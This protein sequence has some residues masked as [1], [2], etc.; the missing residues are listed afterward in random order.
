MSMET[1]AQSTEDILS[2]L[3]GRIAIVGNATPRHEFGEVIDQYD[4]VIRLNNFRIAGFEKFVGSKTS[5]RCT[6]GWTDIEHRN[7]HLEFSPFTAASAESTNLEAYNRANAR[8]LL[9]ARTDIHPL[10]PETAK[11]STGFS[12]IQLCAQ[13][14]LSVDLFGFD[15]FKSPHYWDAQKTFS[16]THSNQE[17]DFILQRPGVLV[18]GDTYAYEKLYDF[19]HEEHSA[20]DQNVGLELVRW[21]KKDFRG[22]A[23]LEFGSGNGQL[24]AHLEK[25]GNN[26][27]AIEASR[28]AFEKI[29]C[30]K[31]IHG[32]ALS[33]PLLQ[34][35]FDCF[36]SVD[37]LEHLTENDCRLVIR[38]AARLAKSIFVSVSTRPSGLLGPNGENLHLTVKPTA[39]WTQ[40]FEKFFT[41][42]T[43]PGYGNGQLVIEGKRKAS[44]ILNLEALT[45][46]QT[47]AERQN[48]FYLNLFTKG[49]AWALATP[50][51]DEA[52]RWQQIE[53]LVR[54]IVTRAETPD[55]TMAGKKP[56]K[57]TGEVPR[58]AS[59]RILDLGC[60]RGWLTHLLSTY[61]QAEGVEPVASVIEH[62]RRLFPALQF[63]A[64]NA[65]TIL[66]R[67]NFT[68][69]D[70]VV[71]SEVIEHVTDKPAFAKD[72]KRLLKPDGHLILTTPRGEALH[73]WTRMF[74]DP[75]QPVEDWMT[76][77]QVKNVF[78][79]SGFRSLEQK[80][81]WFDTV[82]RFFTDGAGVT[83]LENFVAIYQVWSFQSVESP[84]P[85]SGSAT[86]V[87]TTY[88][89]QCRAAA[90][91][92]LEKLPAHPALLTARGNALLELGEFEL[93]RGCLHRSGRAASRFYPRPRIVCPHPL[94]ARAKRGGRVPRN[95]RPTTAGNI[96]SCD[97]FESL[98][99]SGPPSESR[100]FVR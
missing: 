64:G 33:L 87:L 17:L 34:Q 78:S 44:C 42:R 50:N 38:E 19:C 7:E 77:P 70:L 11:P 8:P 89:A 15:G 80:R 4:H 94:P 69:Y 9:A 10:I 62:A 66:Q 1:T 59:F 56:D 14:G 25:S 2:A 13:L 98:F 40:Q 82:R 35:C 26:V 29:P 43:F 65:E 57:M 74:G 3:R 75:S 93:A 16:T 68:P 81:V 84:D 76:E 88:H 12:L 100:T 21:C 86:N 18:Y 32:T 63:T 67:E 24:A 61:G 20:Y 23:M 52:A 39:W 97:P 49:D 55:S 83:S 72:L 46:D 85:E 41:V 45:S 48:E 91:R 22:L 28:F 51:E 47:D 73:E 5:L 60:G 90:E 36:I 6:S 27:T 99:V 79:Q 30:A 37:V 31:K 71:S 96:F 58:P 53:S 54:S 92:A 95:A